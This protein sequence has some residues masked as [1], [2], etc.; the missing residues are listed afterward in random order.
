MK[1]L[2]LILPLLA[3]ACTVAPPDNAREITL[4]VDISPDYTGLTIPR[5]IAPLNFLI[6]LD[7]DDFITVARGSNAGAITVRGP[8]ARFP[9]KAWRDLLD[10]N[11]GAAI[12]FEIY[13]KRD[14][15]WLKLPRVRNTVS[16]DDIDPYI[17]YRLIEPGY[18]YYWDLA[19]RQRDLTSFDE[20][21]IF[22]NKNSPRDTRRLCINCHAYQ[23]YNPEKMQLHGRG[24]NGGTII[25]R[26]NKLFKVNL[27]T[28]DLVSNGV[29]PAWHPSEN[30]IAY[31][32]SQTG[33]VFH[34]VD[35]R[36]VEVQDL[37]SDLVLYDADR[38]TVA[39]IAADTAELETFPAWSPRGDYLYYSS[40]AYAPTHA[41]RSLNALV[42]YRDIQYNI[43][44][45]PFDPVSRQFGEPETVVDAALAGKSA[46]LPR[47]SPDGRYLLYSLGD[48]GI[49]HVWHPES[50]LHLLDLESG[51]AAPLEAANSSSAESYHSWSS[52][53]RWIIFSSRRDDGSFTR[54]Y[55]ARVD[56]Q[57][58]DSKAFV[59]P[60]RDPGLYDRLYKSFNVPEFMTSP[61]TLSPRAISRAFDSE[62]VVPRLLPR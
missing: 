48:F 33:Q 62:A 50:D 27:K 41:N 21:D 59:L 44:R 55:I 53:G 45:R 51:D 31:S 18:V 38:N 24:A 28:G 19:I 42:N 29:Y 37:V 7:A 35:A 12:F 22:N 4:P 34:S 39:Y 15:E 14:G 46:T 6:R 3:V 26:D 23:S 30:L 47:V 49:F 36:K 5:N 9:R 1:P 11:S 40:A 16:T 2:L 25:A 32:V 20:R 13:I 54:L 58:R 57:G 43:L 60:Q 10:K 56:E 17:S 8:S 61:V 52:S